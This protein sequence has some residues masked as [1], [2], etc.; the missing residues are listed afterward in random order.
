MADYLVPLLV[1]LGS[2]SAGA[3]AY[4]LGYAH[5]RRAMAQEIVETLSAHRR[6]APPPP[7]EGPGLH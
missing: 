1:C 6:R 3:V 4:T 2:A 7:P 5:G